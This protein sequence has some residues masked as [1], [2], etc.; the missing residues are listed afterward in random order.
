[1]SP[2]GELNTKLNIELQITGGLSRTP[3]F[4]IEIGFFGTRPIGLFS[5]G[6]LG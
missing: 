1:V 5:Y 2:L 6:M 4:E 3:G